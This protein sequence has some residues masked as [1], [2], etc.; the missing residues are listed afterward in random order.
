ML[1]GRDAP[2]LLFAAR[3]HRQ[4][5]A[6][7]QGIEVQRADPIPGGIERV[8]HRLDILLTS[9]T[10]TPKLAAPTDKNR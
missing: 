7:V 5:L 10:H 4:L 9:W 8:E 6:R 3:Q 1:D 2:A